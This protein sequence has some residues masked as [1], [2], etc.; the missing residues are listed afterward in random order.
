MGRKVQ[1]SSSLFDTI[2]IAEVISVNSSNCS[3]SG[4]KLWRIH[5]CMHTYFRYSA[6]EGCNSSCCFLSVPKAGNRENDCITSFKMAFLFCLTFCLF[7]CICLLPLQMKTVYIQILP[8]PYK[9]G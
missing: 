3:S 7:G 5:A 8:P 9:A 6:K 2:N 1:K 4:G